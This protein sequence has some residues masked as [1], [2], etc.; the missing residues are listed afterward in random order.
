MGK[1]TIQDMTHR[2]GQE[3]L[4]SSS[5]GETSSMNPVPSKSSNRETLSFS[6]RNAVRSGV[7]LGL[8]HLGQ[9][10]HCVTEHY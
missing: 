10:Y 7:S 9:W 2:Q 1:E 3:V 4:P 8:G 6:Q 5:T